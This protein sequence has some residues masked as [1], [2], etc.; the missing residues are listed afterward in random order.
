MQNYIKPIILIH[1]ID[2]KISTVLYSSLLNKIRKSKRVKLERFKFYEDALRSLF[3]E[4]L[5]KYALE[6]H[7]TVD[8]DNEIITE[9]EFGKP[10]LKNKQITFNIS[11]S[12]NWSVIVCSTNNSG[13]DIE[14]IG[15]PPYEIMYKNFTQSEIEQIQEYS[16][17]D[18]VEKFYQIWTLKESYIKML[19]KG[20]TKPLD[21]FSIDAFSD[22]NLNVKENNQKISDVHFR[23]F[24]LDLEHIM[25]VCMR[26]YNKE[27]VPFRINIDDLC[28]FN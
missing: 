6:K 5:L 2:F 7:F 12:G 16:N 11:H 24:R 25:A 26:N 13:I 3:G 21:S 28:C 1:K 18:K 15:K 27:I 19:G 10:F 4:L 20:L 14:K 8:Y 23:L 17:E 22:N 9:N